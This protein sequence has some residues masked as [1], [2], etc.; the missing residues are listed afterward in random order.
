MVAAGRSPASSGRCGRRRRR[1][2][3]TPRKNAR[4][5]PSSTPDSAS[6]LAPP[7]STPDSASAP[8]PPL[9]GRLPT[10]AA[11]EVRIDD[12]GFH[13]SWFEAR[14]LGFSPARGRGFPAQYKVTY[15]DLVAD[16]GSGV[17]SEYFAP[18]HVRP[19]PP[20]TPPSSPP[21]GL[22]DIVEAFHHDGWW[23]GIV[24]AAPAA[25]AGPVTVAFPVTREVIPFPP[26]L[27]R[28]RRDY[29]AG[30]WVLSRAVVA[31]RPKRAVKTYIVGE[32]VEVGRN[33]EVFGYSWFPATVTKVVDPLSYVVE[34]LDLDV[35]GDAGVEKATEYL[36]WLFIRPA[37]EHV[38]LESEF[39]LG[40][41]AAVEAYC[42][43]AWSPGIVLR[44][45]GD[46]EYE[47]SI[48]GKEEKV[49]VT[50]V[51][52][53][54]KPQYKWNGKKWTIVIAKVIM[55][56]IHVLALLATLSQILCG[57]LV[58]R[59]CKIYSFSPCLRISVHRFS[60]IPLCISW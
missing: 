31:V 46:G 15:S 41:G 30:E 55:Q 29:V 13:G 58:Y 11:V 51:K 53:L 5:P 6:A 34:Y 23:S 44:F 40:P 59:Y 9:A 16:D 19:R 48:D 37:V 12:E 8:A 36:H 26:N 45:V 17:L 52:A 43:G 21:L 42:D 50:K 3:T 32:K 7:S 20:P 27:V 24:V 1:G 14:V 39:C 18:S 10:D 22:H 49:L 33:R 25:S 57:N 56:S 28:P 54:L 2:W 38:P 47:V 4:P 60:L 35:E